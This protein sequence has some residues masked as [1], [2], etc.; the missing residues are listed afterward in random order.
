MRR[1]FCATLLVVGCA[2]LPLR[3]VCLAQIT[4]VPGP[5]RTVPRGP[6][7]AATADFNNDGLADAVI[8]NTISSKITVR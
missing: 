1:G 5:P 6:Q 7:F 4:F 2:I 8:S 3:S